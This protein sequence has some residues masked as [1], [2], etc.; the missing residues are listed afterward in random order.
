[1]L[2]GVEFTYHNDGELKSE[3]TYKQGKLDGIYIDY[4][5]NGKKLFYKEK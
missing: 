2:H 5:R 3:K 1:M 4:H